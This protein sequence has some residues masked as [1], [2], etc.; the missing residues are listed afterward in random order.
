MNNT[1]RVQSYS[2]NIIQNF[3]MAGISQS[4][5]KARIQMPIRQHVNISPEVLYSLYGAE[6]EMYGYLKFIFPCKISIEHNCNQSLVPRFFTFMST[7]PE[8]INSYYHC[9]IFHEQVNKFD[10]LHED[11]ESIEEVVRKLKKKH[12][13]PRNRI[14]SNVAALFNDPED[15]SGVGALDTNLRRK[16]K[17]GTVH[18]KNKDYSKDD[19][20]TVGTP[21]T[22]Q[23]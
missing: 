4:E 2:N 1:S 17:R 13:N 16:T 19:T 10:L 3:M 20:D 11:D 6:E 12:K 9:L 21:S 18:I 5:L 8:G 23:E 14:S 22:K 15:D 7:N